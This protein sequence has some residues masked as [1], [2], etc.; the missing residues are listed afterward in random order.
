MDEKYNIV[1]NTEGQST[2]LSYCKFT[3]IADNLELV[4]SRIKEIALIIAKE[5][6]DLWHEDTWY[7][8]EILPAWF[9]QKINSN[10]LEMVFKINVLWDYES[11]IYA[12]KYRGWEWHS[13][14]ISDEEG[15]II[16]LINEMPYSIGTLEYIIYEAGVQA[17]KITFEEIL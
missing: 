6:P 7:W 8:N 15:E 4:M 16:L 9:Q 10:T 3:F 13:S 17:D 5:D 1:Y 14:K 11:W 12:L 2:N